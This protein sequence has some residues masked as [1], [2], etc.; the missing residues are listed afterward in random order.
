MHARICLGTLHPGDQLLK[1]HAAEIIVRI[2]LYWF[3]T[4]QDEV[5]QIYSDYY[6]TW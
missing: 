5:I 1:I 6:F 4:G 3:K 2:G